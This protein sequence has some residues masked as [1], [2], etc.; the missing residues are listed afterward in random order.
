MN[1]CRTFS[2]PRPIKPYHLNRNLISCPSPFNVSTQFHSYYSTQRL[3]FIPHIWR[4]VAFCETHL[5]KARSICT[6]RPK[7]NQEQILILPQLDKKNGFHVYSDHTKWTSMRITLR[8]RFAFVTNL[9]YKSWDKMSSFDIK[10]LEMKNLMQEYLNKS[11]FIYRI[12][13]V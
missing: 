4:K 5:R 2:K 13:R 8:K 9:G 11:V 3:S 1:I 12:H 7:T 6:T 10:K